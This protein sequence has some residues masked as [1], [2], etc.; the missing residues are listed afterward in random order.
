M[1][2]FEVCG[3]GGIPF[4]LYAERG[5]FGFGSLSVLVDNQVGEGDIGAFRSE[6]QS[7]GLTDTACGTGYD[8]HFSFE[9]FHNLNIFK[10][11]F[12][13]FPAQR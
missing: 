12:A 4:S 1:G 10:V 11:I 7:D 9:Q 6:F 2:L 13:N 3:I 8:S 5:D